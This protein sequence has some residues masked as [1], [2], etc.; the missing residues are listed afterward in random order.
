MPEASAV[1]SVGGRW[2]ACTTCPSQTTTARSMRVL[3]LAHVARPVIAHQHVDGGRRDPLD[4]LAVGARGLLE[5]MI[6]E[7]QQIGLPLAQRRNEDREHVE[8]VVQILAERAVGDRLLEVL[9]GRGDQPHVRLECV[10]GAA[11]PLELAL[12]QHAQQLHLRRQVQLA[13]FVEEQRAAFGELEA[14]LLR[15]CAPVNAPFS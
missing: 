6:G 3:E 12:L 14:P 13:D 7:Q 10:F 11:Q 15:R 5:K 9:V 2:C 1:C 8:P 4:V